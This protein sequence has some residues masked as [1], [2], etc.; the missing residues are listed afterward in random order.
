MRYLF[1]FCLATTL[2][3]SLPSNA[4]AQSWPNKPVRIV[5]PQ[6]AGGG[7]DSVG[8]LIAQHLSKTLKAN[9][10]VENRGGASGM[11]GSAMVASAPPDG[12]NFVISGMPSHIVGP[13]SKANP[14]YDPVSDFTHVAHVGGAPLVFLAHPSLN[15]KSMKELTE[16]ARHTTLSYGTPGV[17]SLGHLVGEYLALKGGLKLTNIPY[18]GGSTMTSD[19]IAGHIK[20]GISSLSPA[21]PLIKARKVVP[22]AVTS[23]ARLKGYPSVP[24]LR[25]HGLDELVAVAWWMVSGPPKLPNEITLRMHDAVNEA[26]QD[27]NLRAALLRQGMEIEPMSQADAARFL[28]REYKR[29]SPIARAALSGK[30]KGR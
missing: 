30:K 20:L 26:L 5:V 14:E 8:R 3:F 24:T 19:L 1:G 27:S 28:A 23:A 22:L 7:A 10:F 25:E 15:V 2:L 9:F 16:L 12:Y 17:G 18:K 13:A 11:I 4:Q 29:W 21:S 6:S